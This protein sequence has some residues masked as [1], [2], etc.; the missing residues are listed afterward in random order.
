[1]HSQPGAPRL[2]W[3]LHVFGLFGFRNEHFSGMQ[4]AVAPRVTG[5]GTQVQ[6]QSD[7]PDSGP[8][9]PGMRS[10]AGGRRTAH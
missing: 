7:L 3:A 1:M 10:R 5:A 2:L 4:R 6:R 8:C 9:R